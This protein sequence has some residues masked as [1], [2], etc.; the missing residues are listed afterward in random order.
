MGQG[1]GRRGSVCRGL[2]CFYISSLLNSFFFY[3]TFSA[4]FG[5][6]SERFKVH[7][8]KGCVPTRYRGF[9]SPSFRNSFIKKSFFRKSLL[10]SPGAMQVASAKLRQIGNEATVC[11]RKLC[12]RLPGLFKRFFYSHEIFNPRTE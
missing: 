6:M 8:W 11:G 3:D 4:L 12:R 5:K 10:M 7:P 1:R 9:E 2:P